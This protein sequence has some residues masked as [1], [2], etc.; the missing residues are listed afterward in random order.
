MKTY[1]GHYDNEGKYLGFYNEEVHSKN[2]PDGCIKLTET[3]W[4]KAISGEYIV[5]NGKQVKYKKTKEE[6][7]EIELMDIRRQRD[8][9]LSKSDWTQ[10]NDVALSTEKINE[11][12]EYRRA[13]RNITNYTPYI[14]PITPI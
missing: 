3:E 13:L 1:Y 9:L 2:I 10:L 5:V 11:W 12:K 14:F 7:D 8:L 6:L 4:Q